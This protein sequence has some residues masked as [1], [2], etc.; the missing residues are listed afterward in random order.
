MRQTL[1]TGREE[2]V[3]N[4]TA[5]SSFSSSWMPASLLSRSIEQQTLLLPQ[6]PSPLQEK[7]GRCLQT[8]IRVR[9]GSGV[10]VRERENPAGE[11]TDALAELRAKSGL[12]LKR[13][14]KVISYLDGHCHCSDGCNTDGG[15]KKILL[16]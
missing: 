3:S 7:E 1:L 12:K 13:W 8:C 2:S 4:T 10:G 6:S 16:A 5:S 15:H 9:K 14:S 11:D